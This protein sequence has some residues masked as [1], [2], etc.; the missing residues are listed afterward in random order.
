[1]SEAHAYPRPQ[2]VRNNWTLL[3]G[4]WDFALDHAARW[5]QPE[6]VQW[7]AQIT[8][9]FSPETEASGIGDTGF[10]QACWYRRTFDAPELAN[11]DRLVL[12]FGAVDYRATVW[13]NDK[14]VA[15]H[16]GGYTPFSAD[17]TDALIEGASQTIVVQALDDPQDLAKP[18]GK[19]D[20]LL[21]P[22]SIWYPRTTGIWQT[23]WM[24]RVPETSIA[25]LQWTPNLARW[26][27]GLEAR[28]DGQR[29]DDL[30]LRVKLYVG[31]IILAD[32][33]YKVVA[34]EVSR[35][36]A[37]SDPGIDDYRNELL[38]SPMQPTL[39]RAHLQLWGRRGQL[40]DEV[41]SYT[42]LRQVGIQGDRF[43]LNGRPYKLRMVLDQGY[44]PG[45]GITAPNDA[46]LQRDVELA[47]AMGFNGVRKH[48][49]IEDPRYLYWA[50]TLGLLVWEEMPSAYRF[51]KKAVER[52]TRE[53]TEV[54]ERDYSHPC[55]VSWVPFNESWGIPDL[56]EIPEQRH[57][58]Q[59]LYHHTRTLD[60]TRPVI[61]NDGWESVATDI[62][63]IHDYAD[64]P[65]EI[66]ERY[67]SDEVVGRLFT[68]ERPGGRLLTIEGHP[69]TG[70]PI[71][72][73]EFGGIAFSEDHGATWGYSR[74][75]SSAAFAGQYRALLE[76][77]RSLSLFAGFCYTQ[78]ADTYQESN[79]LLYADRTP[80]FPLDEMAFASRG[81]KTP[82]EQQ[83]EREWRERLQR[84]QREHQVLLE[85]PAAEI[86]EEVPE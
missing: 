56:P 2:L 32:D 1:M 71:M 79:G 8:V 11:D 35:R 22:H 38:W 33:T 84:F 34:G 73:T 85:D 3:N 55:I 4:T 21:E 65:E 63:G 50:D 81:P 39:I 46:A 19:Q 5:S 57:Y 24:E 36:I 7:N 9:P 12:H 13:V 20:W 52:L 25:S 10:Y 17:L 28:M 53:W 48:Q 31:N 51:T 40:V 80:K 67:H 59:T 64:D 41:H 77:V 82:H 58:V 78:F 76:E 70:Q 16:E 74:S 54:I 60:S 62:I 66:A 86:I 18:R 42:A 30:R 68:R 61:G 83:I 29:R 75:E 72:L 69:H 23:V 14:L 37:L 47:K 49:K 15:Q 26:E 27:L 45:S 6:H 44:W 43:V